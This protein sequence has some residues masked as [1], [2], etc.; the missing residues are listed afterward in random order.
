MNDFTTSLEARTGCFPSA[1]SEHYTRSVLSQS[2][3]AEQIPYAQILQFWKRKST[4]IFC[5]ALV[6]TN[7]SEERIASI[8]KVTRIGK[9][10]SDD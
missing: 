7:V 5:V 2:S 3:P 8:I 4:V 6:R 1:A 10:H 9:H